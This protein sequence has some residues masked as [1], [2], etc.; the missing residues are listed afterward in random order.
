MAQEL[1]INSTGSALAVGGETTAAWTVAESV[2]NP[3]DANLRT[4]ADAN[5]VAVM[6]TGPSAAE[7]AQVAT[8][9]GGTLA[10]ADFSAITDAR[11]GATAAIF[12]AAV[13]ANAAGAEFVAGLTAAERV[14]LATSL[15][16][17]PPTLTQALRETQRANA[18][19]LLDDPQMLS[20]R[21]GWRRV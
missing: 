18:I 13:V 1:I 16:A 7:K 20:V 12:A 2:N 17:S 19:A 11:V 3:T 6:Q 5:G 9:L 4:L 15:A 10:A 14:S 8:L 21:K